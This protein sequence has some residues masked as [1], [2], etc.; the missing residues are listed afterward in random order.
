MGK[1]MSAYV[2]GWS[3][4][5]DYKGRSTRL[6]YYTFILVNGVLNIGYKVGALVY[7]VATDPSRS[8]LIGL[9]IAWTII[10]VTTSVPE[11]ALIVRRLRDT[12]RG[13]RLILLFFI[14]IA[15]WLCRWWFLR[16]PT[17]PPTSNQDGAHQPR[18][19]QSQ[20]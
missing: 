9:L 16:Q 2:A 11:F 1:I 20:G 3:R 15:G 5:F 17:R 4:T 8:V 6:E 19:V 13:R 18:V 10:F 14:P 7:I 12:G